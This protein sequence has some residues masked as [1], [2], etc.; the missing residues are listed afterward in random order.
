MTR[1]QGHLLAVPMVGARPSAMATAGIGRGVLAAKMENTSP[2]KE[3]PRETY[4]KVALDMTRRMVGNMWA[5]RSAVPTSGSPVKLGQQEIYVKEAPA[6]G[7]RKVGSSSE[8]AS[9]ASP[10]L[11]RCG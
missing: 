8:A 6:I 4:A 11:R 2:V 9:A 7:R 1:F 5:K 10:L 3:G